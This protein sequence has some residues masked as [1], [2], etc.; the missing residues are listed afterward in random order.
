MSADTRVTYGAR[1]TWWGDIS[2]VGSVGP[3][4]LPCCPHCKGMLFEMPHRDQFLAGAERYEREKPEP[5]YVDMIKWAEGRCFPSFD[6]LKKA[7]S[8]RDLQ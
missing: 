2:A 8:A 4:R 1:C 5:D 6:A 7:Y 3:S